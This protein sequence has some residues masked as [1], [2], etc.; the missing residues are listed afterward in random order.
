MEPF[1]RFETPVGDMM[2]SNGQPERAFVQSSPCLEVL[3]RSDKLF[4]YT[5]P[6]PAAQRPFD[7]AFYRHDPLGYVPSDARSVVSQAYSSVP[8]FANGTG[9]PF[10][11]LGGIKKGTYSSYASS[12][13]S[14]Q[15][16]SQRS[17]AASSAYDYKGGDDE[18]ASYAPSQSGVTEF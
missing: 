17:E 3:N 6:V 2:S 14:Q 9:G 12:I 16:L 18:T 8:L 10:T 5:E 13:I 11:R 4:S 15:E 7:S 1:K